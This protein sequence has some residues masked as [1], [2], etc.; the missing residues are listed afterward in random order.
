M[1]LGSYVLFP[2]WCRRQPDNDADSCI[3]Q[4][5]LRDDVVTVSSHRWES[6]LT[7]NQNGKRPTQ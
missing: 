6:Q 3:R 2:R 1:M 4:R 7:F 5:C